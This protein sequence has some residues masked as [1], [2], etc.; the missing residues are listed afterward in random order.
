[1]NRQQFSNLLQA[2]KHGFI[3]GVFIS[4]CFYVVIRIMFFEFR[5]S[6]A[7]EVSNVAKTLLIGGVMISLGIIF[8]LSLE[9]IIRYFSNLKVR[10]SKPIMVRSAVIAVLV[11]VAAVA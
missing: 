5:L 8:F 2:S 10:L 7:E 9:M 1:M 11:L 3:L 4:F 6:F